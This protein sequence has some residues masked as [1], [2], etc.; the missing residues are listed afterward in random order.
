VRIQSVLLIFFFVWFFLL[1]FGRLVVGQEA[2]PV[3]LRGTVVTPE[4]VIVDGFVSVVGERVSGVG[5]FAKHPVGSN[6]IE[7]DSII[8]P[9]LIDLHDHITWNLLPRWKPNGLF[10]DR[11]D[12]QQLTSYNIALST[13]HTRLYD[14]KLQCEMNLYGE[15]KAIVNG[16][17]SVVGSLSPTRDDPNYN[18]CV[19]GLAR[20]LDFYSGL[21]EKGVVNKEKLRYEVFPFQLSDAGDVVAQLKDGRLT[22]FIAHVAEGKPTDAS[23]AREFTMFKKQGFLVKGATIVHGVALAQPQFKDMAAQAVGLVWSPRSNVELYG[24]T[25]DITT[26]RNEKVKIALAPDWSPSG[27]DGMLEEMKYA[28]TWNAGTVDPSTQKT[29]FQDSDIVK[30]TT[31]QPAEL[32][33]LGDKIGKIAPNMYA[34]LVIL[35]QTRPDP[36]QSLVH[37]SAVDVNLVMIG[38]TAIYG[39][40]AL[41]RKLLPTA[42]LE[43]ITICKSQKLLSTDTYVYGKGTNKVWETATRKLRSDLGQWGTSLAPLVECSEE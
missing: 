7:T 13:P 36:Y 11:Y 9:G 14:D 31:I 1:G 41:M 15:V 39:D 16:A 42:R 25:T 22:A 33:G 23:A 30:M 3:V 10:S 4:E 12:W 8:A 21:Y 37:S 28:A 29:I 18:L 19:Q 32:A 5:P 6:V 40:P 35:K 27:S 34:D 20:N 17:T 2:Q 38:G 26:A 24:S 43:S